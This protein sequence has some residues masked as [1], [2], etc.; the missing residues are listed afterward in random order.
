MILIKSHQ[1][2]TVTINCTGPGALN[3]AQAN[4]SAASNLFPVGGYHIMQDFAWGIH[5]QLCFHFEVEGEKH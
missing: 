2:S 4:F 5:T 3:T 1:L